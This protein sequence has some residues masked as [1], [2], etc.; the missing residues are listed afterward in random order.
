MCVCVYELWYNMSKYLHGILQLARIK[1][2]AFMLFLVFDVR[3]CVCSIPPIPLF[4]MYNFSG[5]KIFCH[6]ILQIKSLPMY[7]YSCN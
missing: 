7:I 5:W 6:F 4:M 1:S 3:T 2:T